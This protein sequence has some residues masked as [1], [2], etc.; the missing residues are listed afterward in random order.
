[1]PD[2]PMKAAVIDTMVFAY[3]LLNETNYGKDSL[4]AIAGTETIHVPDSVR[5]ELTNV[6]WQWITRKAI[7]VQTGLD[8]L[9]DA[10]TL[11]NQVHPS[12]HYWR[13]ALILAC[14]NKHPAYDTLFIAVAKAQVIPLVTY[15]KKLLQKYPD[16]TVRSDVYIQA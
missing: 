7:S 2:K 3:G 6:L 12:E 4:A 1:M 5:P 10:N 15:D 11:F 13:E 9:Q 16:I 14:E 8:L